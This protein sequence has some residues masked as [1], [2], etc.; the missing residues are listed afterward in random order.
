MK[1]LVSITGEPEFCAKGCDNCSNG[2]GCIVQSVQLW[3]PDF[4]DWTDVELCEGCLL[5]Y[6]NGE[7]LPE[8]CK[9]EFGF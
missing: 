7:P 9:N 8:Q 4:S 5:S 1:Y 3:E 2:L 6:H